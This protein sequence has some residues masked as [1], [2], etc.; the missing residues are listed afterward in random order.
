M[1]Y[2]KLL[3]KLPENLIINYERWLF[4]NGRDDI[5]EALSEWVCRDAEFEMVASETVHGLFN[6]FPQGSKNYNKNQN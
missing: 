2:L 4:E 5:V 1:L 3:K 6:S